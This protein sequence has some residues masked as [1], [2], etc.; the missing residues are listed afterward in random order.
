VAEWGLPGSVKDVQAFLGFANYYR[1]F[2]PRFSHIAAPLTQLLQKDVPWKWSIA[3]QASFDALKKAFE[4]QV[5]LAFPDFSAPFVVETDA[6]TFALAGILSQA[7]ASGDLRPVAFYSRKFTSAECN[8]E[9]YDQELLAI[10]ACFAVWRHYLVGGPHKIEVY[11]DHRNLQWFT[12]S[13][14]LNR[15]QV[16]WSLFFADYDFEIIHCPGS[17]CKPDALSR[18]PDYKR[19]MPTLEERSLLQPAQLVPQPT[20]VNAFRICTTQVLQDPLFQTIRDAL[21]QD[22]VY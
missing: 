1:K 16:R 10:R 11:S 4:L 14:Q 6:S 13:R 7:D 21:P 17:L 3:A 8:Y 12:A 9:T 18:R 2:I 19:D 22:H 15:R 20:R 5:V